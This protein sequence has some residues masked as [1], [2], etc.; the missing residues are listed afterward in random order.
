MST[1]SAER[2]VLVAE[3]TQLMRRTGQ[4]ARDPEVRATLQGAAERLNGP[5]RLAVAGRIKAGKSTLLNALLGEDLAATDAGECTTLVTWYRFGG[6]PGVVV[7]LRDGSRTDARWSR[8]DDA[9]DIQLGGIPAER[10]DHLEVAWPSNRLRDLT[11]LDTP[12]IASLSTSVS[13]RTHAVLSADEGRV[14]VADAVI[15]LMRHTHA[16]DVR[17]LD[18]FHDDELGHGTPMNAIG[19]LSRADEIGSCRLRAMQDAGRIAAR[20]Q[21]DPRLRRLCP[22][23]VPVAGLLGL[24]AVT[25]R[26]AEYAM[27]ASVAGL[28][29]S[30]ADGLLLTADRFAFRPTSSALTRLEREHLLSRLGL[31]GIRLAVHLIRTGAVNSATELAAQLERHSGLDRLRGVVARQFE[32]RSRILKVR[33]ALSTLEQVLRDETVPDTEVLRSELEQ[34]TL[35]TH[36]FQE[37]RLL[38]ELRSDSIDLKQERLDELERLVGG[39]GHDACSRLGMPEGS[40]GAEIRAAAVQAL[41]RWRR[42]AEHPLSTRSTQL[43]ARTATRTLEGLIAATDPAEP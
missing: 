29:R 37:L 22:V 8:E 11:V 18:S 27:L 5:L 13:A 42:T 32:Q 10:V 7:H 41:E 35:R 25:L 9:L 23:V 16:S 12:G 1:L 40:G 19:V 24:A 30:E 43:A 21:R 14:P 20:Y 15:Y 26:E 38:S 17:F 6:T 39:S 28:A 31:F 36:E 34:I 33:S 2:D 4:A 3:V